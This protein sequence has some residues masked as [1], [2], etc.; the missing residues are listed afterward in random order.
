[1]EYHINLVCL[2]GQ[3]M[4]ANTLLT[5]CHPISK[6]RSGTNMEARKGRK[7]KLSAFPPPSGHM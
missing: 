7:Q 1:M 5:D 4:C 2:P 3:V 6:G